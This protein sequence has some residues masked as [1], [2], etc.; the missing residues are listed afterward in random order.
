M[1]LTL[2]AEESKTSRKLAIL[3]CVENLEEKAILIINHGSTQYSR[4]T[5]ISTNRWEK[6][7]E[8][9]HEGMERWLLLVQIFKRDKDMKY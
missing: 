1:H 6:A 7:D 3:K 5:G 2:I 4:T 8:G 9:L